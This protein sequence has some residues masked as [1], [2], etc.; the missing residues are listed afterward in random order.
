MTKVFYWCPYL[1]HVATIENVIK[2]AI[3]LTKYNEINQVTLLD[4]FGEWQFEKNK[5]IKNKIYIEK[6]SKLNFKPNKVGFLNL[7]FI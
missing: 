7:D 6:L 3:S 4:T 1:S 5:L 2:S